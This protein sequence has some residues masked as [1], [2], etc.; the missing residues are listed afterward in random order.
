MLALSQQP[1]PFSTE[2]DQF[3]S[4]CAGQV[5]SQRCAERSVTIESY[6]GLRHRKWHGLPAI[7]IESWSG[8]WREQGCTRLQRAKRGGGACGLL[9]EPPTRPAVTCLKGRR[10]SA[11]TRPDSRESLSSSTHSAP[12]LIMPAIIC[13]SS[14]AFS[15]LGYAHL[16]PAMMTGVAQVAERS[17]RAVQC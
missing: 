10:I 16:H 14:L 3:L 12:L 15:L 13:L 6:P 17:T 7:E 8:T 4:S 2:A 1:V 9:S 11:E 5:F